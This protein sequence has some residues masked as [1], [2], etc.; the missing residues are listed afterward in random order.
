MLLGNVRYLADIND[1]HHRIGRC[2]YVDCL[3]ILL[4]ISLNVFL[5]TVNVAESQTVL[6]VYMVKKPDTAAI[7]ICICND[8]VSRL[9]YLH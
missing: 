2:L 6:L 1:I 8:V 9:E 7:Q 3:C 5:C 4:N